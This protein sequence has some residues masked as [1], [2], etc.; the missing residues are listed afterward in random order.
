MHLLSHR[1]EAAL[2]THPVAAK[3]TLPLRGTT[4]RTPR[5]TLMCRAKQVAH[6]R[7]E[8]SATS[9]QTP[10]TW[11]EP[12][13]HARTQ[14][15]DQTLPGSLQTKI[16]PRTLHF[17]HCLLFLSSDVNSWCNP[18]NNMDKFLACYFWQ[19]LP[20]RKE[21][22]YTAGYS[23]K[24]ARR[25]QTRFLAHTALMINPGQAEQTVSTS[26]RAWNGRHCARQPAYAFRTCYLFIK[27]I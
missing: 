26:E 24:L 6:Q 13:H 17:L 9:F 8:A 25:P 18:R 22:D 20:P 15:G 27:H 2:H 23:G 5:L 3:G 7:A 21:G 14:G 19:L 16:T 4:G 1:H 10:R 11:G 12:P